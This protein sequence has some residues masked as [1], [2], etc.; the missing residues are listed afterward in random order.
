MKKKCLFYVLTIF[1]LLFSSCDNRNIKQVVKEI[2]EAPAD[3]AGLVRQVVQTNAFSGVEID[4]FADV[5]Y[6]Q[7]ASG[8]EP[9]VELLA[10]NDVLSHVSVKT[11]ED[12][13]LISTDRRYRMPEKAVVVVN[14]Y[15]PFINKF[16]LN[17]G[18]CIR[19][20]NIQLYAPITIDVQGVGAI[21]ADSLKAQEVDVNIDGAGSIDL[22]NIETSRLA[23][24][25]NGA[26][27]IFLAGHAGEASVAING[28]GTVDTSS[29]KC[30]RPVGKNK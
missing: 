8:T 26:G 15:A 20:G 17:G 30:D 27:Q 5:T 11:T 19:L 9:Y 24:S 14:V 13:L 22:K 3:T 7:T 18:K 23:A 12:M 6:H 2:A 16:S 29:L 28:A 10:L 21:T 1:C 25:I 4:C